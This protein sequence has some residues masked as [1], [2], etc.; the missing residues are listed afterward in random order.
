MRVQNIVAQS[1]DPEDPPHSVCD[2][3]SN[4]T[5]PILETNTSK[6]KSPKNSK[7]DDAKPE[8]IEGDTSS[9][10]TGDP[11]KKKSSDKFEMTQTKTVTDDV[12]IPFK[13]GD[14]SEIK[15]PLSK[16]AQ[17]DPGS[18]AVPSIYPQISQNQKS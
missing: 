10:T 17:D 2:P 12:E 3:E 6:D 11:E 14:G 13:N 4:P 1:P 7:N 16:S 15:D 8:S 5:V 18:P 9:T